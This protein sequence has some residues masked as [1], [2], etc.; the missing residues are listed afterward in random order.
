MV[1]MPS[2]AKGETPP[3]NKN[4][5][6]V[7]I[8]VI[9]E[10]E[11]RAITTVNAQVTPSSS[12]PAQTSDQPLNSSIPGSDPTQQQYES[13]PVVNATPVPWVEVV[14]Q[15]VLETTVNALI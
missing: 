12:V 3:T 13:R 5:T 11:A 8:R 2:R 14:K 7:E 9:G 10:V 15:N 1:L 6:T 4:P